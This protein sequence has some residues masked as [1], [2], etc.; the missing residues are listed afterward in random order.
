MFLVEVNANTE[1]K[2]KAS[3][4]QKNNK[5]KKKMYH[6]NIQLLL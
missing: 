1:V 6:Q 5:R 3:T 4:K 2:N